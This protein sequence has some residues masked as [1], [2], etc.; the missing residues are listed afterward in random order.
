MDLSPKERTWEQ[1]GQITEK[2]ELRK[3]ERHL[4][5]PGRFRF[6]EKAE[7]TGSDSDDNAQIEADFHFNLEERF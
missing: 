3:I 2:K 1:H 6:G 7:K 4:Q 5:A